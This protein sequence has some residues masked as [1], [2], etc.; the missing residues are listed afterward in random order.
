MTSPPTNPYRM[1]LFALVAGFIV[2]SVAEVWLLTVVGT[3]VGVGWTLAILLAEAVVGAVLLRHEGRKSWR[4]LVAA[5]EAGRVPTGQLADAALVLA[6]GIMLIL[7]G[8]VTDIVGLIF[9]LPFTRPYARKSVGWIVAHS[10]LRDAPRGTGSWP[11]SGASNN[12]PRVVPGEVVTDPPKPDP[13]SGP[14]EKE[15]G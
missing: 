7:P 3:A 4:A 5:Y 11:R 8:F 10:A 12:D 9:L 13:T 14:G 2:L 15:L 1:L 6:G